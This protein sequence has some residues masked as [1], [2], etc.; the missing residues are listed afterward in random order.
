[1]VINK[2]NNLVLFKPRVENKE[3]PRHDANGTTPMLQ[4]ALEIVHGNALDYNALG[5]RHRVGEPEF[6]Y[7]FRGQDSTPEN[8]LLA[9]GK[10]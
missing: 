9:P 7:L 6:K 3:T 1:M 4:D 5:F 8:C 2:D 10:Q